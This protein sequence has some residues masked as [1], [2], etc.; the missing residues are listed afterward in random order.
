REL[1]GLLGVGPGAVLPGTNMPVYAHALLHAVLAVFAAA[2]VSGAFAERVRFGAYCLFL[3]A[4]SL[5]VYAPVAHWVWATE[6]GAPA[7]WLGQLGV[8]DTAGG[9]VVHLAAGVAG[10][11]AVVMLRP[12]HGH[13]NMAAPPGSLALALAGAGLLGLGWLGAAGA[14]ALGANAR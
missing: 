5:L 11:A 2:L 4:W 6:R 10:A 9:S 8:L 7:G 14:T 13:P 3:P 12:R 1:V